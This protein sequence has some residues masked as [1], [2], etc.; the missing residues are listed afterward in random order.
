MKST[1]KVTRVKLQMDQTHDFILLG[2]VSSEPDYKLS[3]SLN[4][5]LRIFLKNIPPVRLTGDKGDELLF[6]RF[7]DAGGS[8][9]KTFT[10]VSNR[11]DKHFLIKKL[12]NIDYLF[13]MHDTDNETSISQATSIL[14]EIEGITAVFN[15]DTDSIK[16]KNLHYVI[17]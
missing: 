1:R 16:D 17:Q 11:F 4:R 15:I 3:L 10:L 2:L 13:Y 14:R 6:S 7:S 5:K 8:P 9:D 12:K